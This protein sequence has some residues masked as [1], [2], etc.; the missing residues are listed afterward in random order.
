MNGEECILPVHLL[1]DRILH[2]LLPDGEKDLILSHARMTATALIALRTSDH[3]MREAYWE[4][5]SDTKNDPLGIREANK[6]LLGCILD[7]RAEDI[8]IWDNTRFVIEEVF[9]DPPRLWHQICEFTQ[10]EWNDQIMVLDMH[11][12]MRI[13][14]GIWHIAREM[15]RW[16]HGDARRI[17]SDICDYPE[18]IVKRLN[19]LGFPP[20]TTSMII[21]ALKDEGLVT[22]PFDVRAD[23]PICRIL[24][25][26]ICGIEEKLS[27]S[28][29]VAVARL[30]YP[31]DPWILDRP[32]YIIGERFC[33]VMPS[34]S[35]CPVYH[36]CL[37]KKLFESGIKASDMVYVVLFGKKTI[38]SSLPSF[39]ISTDPGQ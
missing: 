22:G 7:R 33:H 8:D 14:N 31:S 38:Q 32:L 25:R 5:L 2:R 4:W 23:A 39:W 15:I 35:V 36:C 1:S 20:T 11:P 17:W 34:C 30:M 29:A 24:A 27:S 16:Y 21:G 18:E 19:R 9:G 28:Q 6:F 10:E 13:Y 3:T 12:D 26:L 37:Y